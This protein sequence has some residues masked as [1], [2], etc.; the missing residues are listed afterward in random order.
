MCKEVLSFQ[1][2]ESYTWVTC[3]SF[4]AMG[5]IEAVEA[6]IQFHNT[7]AGEIYAFSAHRKTHLVN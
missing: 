7:Y 2:A 6:Q 3:P 1:C 5:D 4:D